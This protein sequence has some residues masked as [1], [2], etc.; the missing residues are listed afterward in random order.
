MKIY[1][2]IISIIFLILILF[3]IINLNIY[4]QSL[5]YTLISTSKPEGFNFRYPTP[6]G[7]YNFKITKDNQDFPTIYFY[8]TNTQN[9]TNSFGFAIKS[10]YTRAFLYSYLQNDPN[11]HI[12]IE[13]RPSY[14]LANQKGK[15]SFLSRL[16]SFNSDLAYLYG[17][18][19][20]LIAVYNCEDYEWRNGGTCLGKRGNP[21]YC[22]ENPYMGEIIFD[23]LIGE[24]DLHPER[25]SGL[26]ICVRKL[27]SLPR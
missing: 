25:S 9:L 13:I 16:S 4:A 21:S 1:Q 23:G 27:Y 22:F 24:D 17:D 19:S 10:F 7:L 5:A 12:V 11:K 14:I 18:V 20:D 3:L 26:T 8:S 6:Y 15:V 2:I